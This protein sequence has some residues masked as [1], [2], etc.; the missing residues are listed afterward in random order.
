MITKEEDAMLTKQVRE[1]M[2]RKKAIINTLKEFDYREIILEN[3]NFFNPLEREKAR[4]GLSSSQ[5]K[6]RRGHLW[7][8][9]ILLQPE[10]VTA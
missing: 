10:E 3:E 8:R 7:R 9:N 2:A 1:E 5:S 4:R 6:D